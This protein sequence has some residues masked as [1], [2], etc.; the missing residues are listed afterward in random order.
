M[1]KTYIGVIHKGCM[2]GYEIIPLDGKEQYMPGWVKPNGVW[3]SAHRIKESITQEEFVKDMKECID[4]F[5]V[6]DR[7]ET[8][9]GR[10]LTDNEIV[11]LGQK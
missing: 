9:L 2:I 4:F 5:E 7:K 10:K 6:C 3:Q 11:K 1:K 8:I